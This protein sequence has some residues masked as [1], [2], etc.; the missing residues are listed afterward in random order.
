MKIKETKNG[1]QFIFKNKFIYGLQSKNDIRLNRFLK[2]KYNLIKKLKISNLFKKKS[3]FATM[4]RHWSI[5]MLELEEHEQLEKEKNNNLSLDDL[6]LNGIVMYDLLPKEYLND[7][8]NKYLKFKNHF[9]SKHFTNKRVKDIKDSFQSMKNSKGAGSWYNIDHFTIKGKTSLSLY[10]K[11]F[12]IEM[13]GLSESF[14]IVKYFLTLSDNAN[15]LFEKIIKSDI[16]KEAY[17]ISQDK[18][19]RTKSFAGCIPYD[20]NNEAKR[21]TIQEYLLEIKSVFFQT[22]QK[23]LFSKIFNWGQIM[24]SIEIYSSNDLKSKYKKIREL[25][26]NINING[27]ECNKE[28][29]LFFMTP[30]RDRHLDNLNASKIIVDSTLIKSNKRGFNDFMLYEDLI[31]KDYGDFFLLETLSYYVDEKIYLSHLKINKAIQKKFKLSNIIGLKFKI[32]KDLYIYRRLYEELNNKEII[33]RL[34]KWKN[35]DYDKYMINSYQLQEECIRFIGFKDVCKSIYYI[36]R[37]KNTLIKKIYAE[38]DNNVSLLESRYNYRTIKWT[39][40]IAVITLFATIMCAKDFYLL[41]KLWN[42]IQSIF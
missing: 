29:T 4:D 40:L 11:N 30:T 34:L 6:T 41:I 24:P 21:K 8:E 35:D 20:I 7:Y 10:Y 5:P 42:L 3:W 13:I 23:Y 14:Y 22:I 36:I 12:S 9:S 27:D 16:Y 32:E 15:K 28:Q 1:L 39:L 31:C 33:D 25:I 18:W 38:L 37:E 26:G 2:L 17:C 19:W